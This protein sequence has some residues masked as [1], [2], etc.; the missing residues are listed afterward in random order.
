MINKININY[1]FVIEQHSN[2][3]MSVIHDL[4]LKKKKKLIL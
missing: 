3:H 4:Q 1:F 2:T